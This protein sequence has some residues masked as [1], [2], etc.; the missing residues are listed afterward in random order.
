VR[1]RIKSINN[2]YLGRLR[3]GE[4]KERGAHLTQPLAAEKI[5]FYSM[6]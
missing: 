1:P 5:R 3:E 6:V 2:Q 4:G